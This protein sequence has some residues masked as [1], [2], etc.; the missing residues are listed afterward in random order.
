MRWREKADLHRRSERLK[1]ARARLGAK[2]TT[3][4]VAIGLREVALPGRSTSISE[5]CLVASFKDG[6]LPRRHTSA[7]SPFACS[8]QPSRP[9]SKHRSQADI[10]L[11]HPNS[12]AWS[13]SGSVSNQQQDL[14]GTSLRCEVYTSQPAHSWSK[15]RGCSAL[16][17]TDRHS[18]PACSTD[19]R[20]RG[21][22]VRRRRRPFD[23]VS[24]GQPRHSG[25]GLLRARRGGS[26]DAVLDA[27]R[28][29][30]LRSI[31]GCTCLGIPLRTV[32]DTFDNTRNTHAESDFLGPTSR[33]GE[34]LD[35]A[36]WFAIFDPALEY[37]HL[38]TV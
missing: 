9:S 10:P 13:A 23:F 15:Q 35:E 20:W 17:Q 37:D 25:Y 29:G 18:I 27:L 34:S 11:A 4:A 30:S 12:Q 33:D 1:N 6:R 32:H 3:H 19:E 24:A 22:S 2:T 36:L 28:P 7:S 21:I 8:G 5:S 14:T 38:P 26:T 16:A 31:A